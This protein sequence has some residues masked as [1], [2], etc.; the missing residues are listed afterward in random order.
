MTATNPLKLT[1]SIMVDKSL[2]DIRKHSCVGLYTHSI[3][4]REIG[5]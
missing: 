1:F 3:Y 2:Q 4:I 5:A